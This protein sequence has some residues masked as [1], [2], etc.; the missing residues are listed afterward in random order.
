MEKLKRK[1]PVAKA[2]GS[3]IFRKRI[4]K[5]KKSYTRKGRGSKPPAFRHLGLST[6]R[7]LALAG[8]TLSANNSR[9]A[10]CNLS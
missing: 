5:N 1:N 10:S 3:P 8:T 9:L 6:T 2:L 7:Y 4:V